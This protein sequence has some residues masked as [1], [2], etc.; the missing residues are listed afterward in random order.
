[1][2]KVEYAF[3]LPEGQERENLGLDEG[4]RVTGA[5]SART[6]CVGVVLA[7]L[8]ACV[9]RED[10][11]PSPPEALLGFL[12][13]TDFQVVPA[14]PG[15][16]YY[17][18]RN[19]TEPWAVHLLRVEL[20]RCELGFKVLEAPVAEGAASGRSLVTELLA[21]EGEGALAGVNGDFFTPEGLPVGTEVVGG[22]TRRA[23]DRPAFAWHPWYDPWMG[24]PK[25]EGDSVLVLG[26]DVSRSRSDGETEAIGG[27]PLLL[28]DGLRVGD[29]EVG[30]RPSF[31]AERHPRTA[32]GFDLDEKVLWVLVVDG[33]QPDYS[34]GMTLPELAALMEALG[35]E[36]AINL[37]GG[38]SSV[39]VVDGIT[40]S[41]PSDAEGERPVV[42][43]LGIR[44]DP[45][46]CRSRSN[47][48]VRAP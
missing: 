13:T 30:E 17:G 34:A 36:E 9:P 47:G 14:G 3:L 21:L 18:L 26:W 10:P 19:L 23:R 29:L 27:F 28:R 24:T 2:V 44:R 40:V 35:V 6:V 42:N 25:L 41:R 16:A 20:R 11:P 46:F 22:L 5:S 8:A 37:D 15:L 4:V 39:M 43:A 45:A 7:L 31:A 38:G 33:R 1:M 48:P 12:E 32:V